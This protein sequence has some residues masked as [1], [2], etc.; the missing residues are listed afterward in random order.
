MAINVGINGFGRI[1]TVAIRAS[2][3]MPEIRIVGINIR[4][5]DLD[6]MVYMLKYDSTFGRFPKTVKKYDEGLIID[7]KKVRVFS[8]GTNV[9]QNT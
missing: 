1:A 9:E 8:L 6:Y 7:G 3:D 5:A 4:N 2:L